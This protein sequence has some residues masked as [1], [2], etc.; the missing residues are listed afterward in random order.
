M[1]LSIKLIESDKAIQQKIN[2]ALVKQINR[3]ISKNLP[4]AQRK[5]LTLIRTSLNSSPEMQSLRTGILKLEFGLDKDPTFDIIE[6]IM[7]SLEIKFSPINPRD[8]SGG[9]LIVLQP[10][11][12]RNL[13]SMPAAYQQI[14]GGSLPW[15]SWLLTL[16]DTVIITRFG[17]EIGDFPDS[18]TGGARMTQKAAPYKVNSAFSGTTEDNFITRSVARVSN[19]IRGI[20]KGVL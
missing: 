16:G 14:D 12:Y 6:S 11:D 1:S 3:S 13:L 9:I 8:F 15:L 18:R 5:I 7:S 19:Q 4:S 20:I 17:V 2:K 10:S